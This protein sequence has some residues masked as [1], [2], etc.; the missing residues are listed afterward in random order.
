M[1]ADILV[2]ASPVYFYGI[3]SQLK[4]P[5][6]RLYTPKIKKLV[7]GVWDKEEIKNNKGL[8]ATYQLGNSIQ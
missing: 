2:V 1:E 7:S 4:S 5:I 8:E 3:N 6:D